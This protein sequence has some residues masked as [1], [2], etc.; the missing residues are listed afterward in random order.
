M[1]LSW[2]NLRSVRQQRELQNLG[3]KLLVI[4]ILQQY[5]G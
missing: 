4:Y 3:S 5:N 1:G 2:Y